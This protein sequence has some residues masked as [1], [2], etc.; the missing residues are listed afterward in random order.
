MLVE[1][2]RIASLPGSPLTA[3]VRTA[4][5]RAAVRWCGAPTAG[6]GEYHVEWTVDE[7]IAWGRNAESAVGTGPEIRPDGQCVVLRG[8]LR[9]AEDGVGLLDLDG[10]TVLLDLT[11]PVPDGVVGTWVELRVARETLALYPYDL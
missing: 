8:H 10:A 4:F 5:G 7:D 3:Q 1:V 9:L 11:A 2:E 6:A